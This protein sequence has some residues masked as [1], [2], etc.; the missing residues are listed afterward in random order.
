MIIGIG[1]DIIE[2]ERVKKAVERNPKFLEKMFT[3]REIE[4]LRSRNL[5]SE[6]IAGSF[7]AK[8]AVSKAL[9]TGIR[10]FAFSD[11]EVLRDSLGKPEVILSDKITKLMNISLKV[12]VSISH[13]NDSAI[14]FAVIEEE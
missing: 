12:Q 1:T 10:G 5:K 13:N 8:E 2:I 4:F 7:S 11:I 14:A 9:G 3:E 6:T